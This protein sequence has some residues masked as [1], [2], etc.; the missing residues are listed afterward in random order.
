ME[1]ENDKF[2][3]LNTGEKRSLWHTE[4][5]AID[6]LQKQIGAIDDPEI[7]AILEVDVSTNDWSITQIPWSKIALELLRG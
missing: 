6:A 7:V 2:Y 4:D 1:I 3:V 5:E